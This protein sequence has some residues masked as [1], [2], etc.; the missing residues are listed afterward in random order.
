MLRALRT[1]VLVLLGSS[2][3]FASALAHHTF[4]TKYD[5]TKLVTVSGVV[6][7]V[8]YSNPHISFQVTAGGTTWTVETESIPVVRGKGITPEV[9]KEGAKVTVT[10]WR[11]RD[12]SAGLGLKSISV[13]GGP[14]ATMRRSAR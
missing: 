10:G 12:G 11:A 14:S 6:T 13:S 5:G 7:S 9:L 4:V 1:L 3:P 2:L 8:S